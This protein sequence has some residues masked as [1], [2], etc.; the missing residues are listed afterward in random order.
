MVEPWN[1]SQQLRHRRRV[2]PFR[3]ATM[4]VEMG[5]L[6]VRW[7]SSKIN[8]SP[9]YSLENPSI[10]LQND[11][12]RKSESEKWRKCSWRNLSKISSRG[13]WAMGISRPRNSSDRK[14]FSAQ[15]TRT[16]TGPCEMHEKPTRSFPVYFIRIDF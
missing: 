1:I 10:C 9:L 8:F 14:Q 7:I 4:C 13:Y 15:L 2:L 16:V 6:D 11:H 5:L 12:R 3:R